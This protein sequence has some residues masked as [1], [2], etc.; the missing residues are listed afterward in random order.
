MKGSLYLVLRHTHGCRQ[1]GY[2]RVAGFVL[3]AISQEPR[4]DD[5]KYLEWQTE[6]EKAHNKA[7]V[8][9]AKQRHGPTGTVKLFFEDKFTKFGDL[10]TVH[11]SAGP[12]Y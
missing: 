8:I 4:E 7:E 11:E 1:S 3:S 9:I 5:P 12:E 6:L 10:D 2:S